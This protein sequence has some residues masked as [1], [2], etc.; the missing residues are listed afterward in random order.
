MPTTRV[1]I[2][3]VLTP[4]IG[5]CVSTLVSVKCIVRDKPTEEKYLVKITQINA[6]L[7]KENAVPERQPNVENDERKQD[8]SS[9]RRRQLKQPLCIAP[10]EA[11]FHPLNT[12]IY[13]VPGARFTA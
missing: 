2:L 8:N 9:K 3:N 11:D 7:R 12:P 6:P 4:P 1:S 5:F 10:A 13:V